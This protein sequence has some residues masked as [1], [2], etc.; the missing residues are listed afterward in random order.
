MPPS[1]PITRRHALMAWAVG[2]LSLA[3]SALR[4]SN[5]PDQPGATHSRPEP[6][7]LGLES[8]L[9]LGVATRSLHLMPVDDVI[10]ALLAL[11]I[12]NA[13][14]SNN[15]LPFDGPIE[16]VREIAAKFHAAGIA[17]T[18]SGA[19]RLPD[20][21]AILRR[22]FENAKAAELAT[23][24]CKPE[25]A[26]LPKLEKLA[27]EFDQ[28]V[29]IHNH[30]P[31]DKLYATSKEVMQHIHSLDARIGICLDV[32][33]TARAGA[34]PA[35]HIHK[36]ARRIYDLHL[37]DSVAEVGARSDIPTEV[38]A[39]RLDIPD[40]LRAL[41]A[42]NYRGVVGF[43]YEKPGGNPLT[44]LAESVGYVRGVLALLPQ[45]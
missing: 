32:A 21:D 18:G 10:K 44:G 30:G 16:D 37:R 5:A 19:I 15:H 17:I 29:A 31:Y 28:R 1:P 4:A 33:H 23:L 43:E 40:I 36:Y 38:G 12:S 13:G 41:I 6:S 42:I 24:V 25:I 3:A 9:R 8:G 45:R 2:S 35:E 26:A 14:V 27:R 39:G 34:D 11:R 20:D 22:V 7:A